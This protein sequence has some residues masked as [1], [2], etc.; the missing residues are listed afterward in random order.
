MLAGLFQKFDL[1]V[2]SNAV[3]GDD[4]GRRHG[5]AGLLKTSVS[6]PGPAVGHG[7]LLWAG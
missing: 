6:A 3:G 1:G 4:L 2:S 7:N 5:L